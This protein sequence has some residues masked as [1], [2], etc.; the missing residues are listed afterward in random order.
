MDKRIELIVHDDGRNEI[1]SNLNGEEL[2]E[3]YCVFTTH[4]ALMLKDKE[5][6]KSIAEQ[7][8]KLAL[9][10]IEN[11]EFIQNQYLN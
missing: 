11:K 6:I 7:A 1:H 8:T 9:D 10:T 2:L 4:V 5:N 3:A